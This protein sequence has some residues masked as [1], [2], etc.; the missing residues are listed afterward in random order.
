M[1]ERAESGKLVAWERRALLT[2]DVFDKSE[3][4]DPT[5]RRLDCDAGLA[6]ERERLRTG[7][8]S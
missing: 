3:S 4:L 2:P 7:G 6:S 8:V 1:L 5:E